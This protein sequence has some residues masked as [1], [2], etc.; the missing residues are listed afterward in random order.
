MR[1]MLCAVASLTLSALPAGE[2]FAQT[3][4]RPPGGPCTDGPYPQFL[5]YKQNHPDN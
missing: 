1:T 3:R 4:N 2:S 5:D